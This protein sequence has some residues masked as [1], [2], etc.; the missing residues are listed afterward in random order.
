MGN[1]DN[2]YGLKVGGPEKNTTTSVYLVME[3]KDAACFW[4]VT[5]YAATE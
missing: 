2:I 4:Q 1:S 3:H 5:G